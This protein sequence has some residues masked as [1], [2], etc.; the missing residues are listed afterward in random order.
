MD[1]MESSKWKPI[2]DCPKNSPSSPLIP[3]YSLRD[4]NDI[5]Y[6]PRQPSQNRHG[7]TIYK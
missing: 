2:S 7:P 3:G 5:S 4:L 6:L 1:L